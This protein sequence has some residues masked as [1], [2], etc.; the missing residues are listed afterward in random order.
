MRCWIGSSLFENELTISI[1]S[2]L[3]RFIQKPKYHYI[4]LRMKTLLIGA[5]NNPDRYAYI[6][7]ERLLAHG[8]ELALVGLRPDVIFGHPIETEKILFA[9]I[10]TVSLYI[11]A[12]RQPEYYSY[13]LEL[14][15]RRVIF[16][17]G[18]ENPDFE[19]LLKKN[20]IQYEEACTLVLL[21][22]GQY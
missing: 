19:L 2:D 8:H 12:L 1:Y 5:S 20:N 10:D 3:F 13:I 14:N 9:N 6:A 21:G 7:A 4:H 17:P 22:T 16:N 15:P 11:G 18:T